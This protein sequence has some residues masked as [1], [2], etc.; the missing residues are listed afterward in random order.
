MTA[1][2][3]AAAAVAAEAWHLAI[4]RVAEPDESRR[5]GIGSTGRGGFG[6][7]VALDLH[8]PNLSRVNAE[9]IMRRAHAL[10]PTRTPRVATSTSR[11]AS[12]VH[13]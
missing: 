9:D 7:A 4:P 3:D 8:A 6:L 5:A 1:G 11:S 10:S 13:S 2:P 12:T